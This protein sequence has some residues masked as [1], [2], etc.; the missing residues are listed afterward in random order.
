MRTLRK[1]ST[2]LRDLLE[3]PV[4]ARQLDLSPAIAALEHAGRKVQL[5]ANGLEF[6]LC[7][8]RKFVVEFVPGPE[9]PSV[10][11]D[12]RKGPKRWEHRGEVQKSQC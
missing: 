11:V 8:G 6:F 10:P 12:T 5:N 2:P 3:E 9:P 4:S 1:K 7:D